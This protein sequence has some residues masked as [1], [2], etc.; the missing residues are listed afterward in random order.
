[1]LPSTVNH[2]NGLY[3]YMAKHITD[4]DTHTHSTLISHSIKFET[5]CSKYVR[6][7]NSEK[8]VPCLT[9][10]YTC[11]IAT[12]TV[13]NNTNIYR[14][15]FY[16]SLILFSFSRNMFQTLNCMFIFSLIIL[17]CKLKL[18]LNIINYNIKKRI[19]IVIII[20]RNCRESNTFDKSQFG[21]IFN[22]NI[23]V[24]ILVAV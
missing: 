23:C 12:W 16:I 21:F 5:E 6:N 9:T 15:I 20:S 18:K 24:E 13:K 1:M 19:C 3:S 22:R 2:I 11:L 8:Y 7:L 4:S 17:K 10:G 14:K